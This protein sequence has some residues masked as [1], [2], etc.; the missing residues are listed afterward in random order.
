MKYLESVFDRIGRWT[1]DDVEMQQLK[2]HLQRQ[3][4]LAVGTGL[5]LTRYSASS[6]VG[7]KLWL[8]DVEF[9]DNTSSC[10]LYIEQDSVVLVIEMN[11]ERI[12]YVVRPSEYTYA[13]WIE[14]VDSS[15]LKDAYMYWAYYRDEVEEYLEQIGTAWRQLVNVE[16][17][18]DNMYRKKDK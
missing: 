15:Q 17:Y 3:L 18:P 8:G 2:L 13:N 7:Y 16:Q 5:E 6:G 14:V 11:T 12:A 1:P 10:G 9:G 4:R